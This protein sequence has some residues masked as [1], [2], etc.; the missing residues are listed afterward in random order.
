[1]RRNTDGFSYACG[2]SHCYICIR[3]WLEESWWCP[4]CM[5]V[6]RVEPH[7]HWRKEKDIAAAYPGWKD[8]SQ[9]SYCWEGLT[10]PDA[11]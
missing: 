7:P 6:I 2:H 3:M 10:F 1:V 5:K 9:V 8:K 11:L 4:T